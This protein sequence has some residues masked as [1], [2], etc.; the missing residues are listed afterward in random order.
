MKIS[1]PITLLDGVTSTGAGSAF[2]LGN[3]QAAFQASVVGTGA[4]T[5]TVNIE[6]S[7]EPRGSSQLWV[8]MGTI[9]LSGTTSA[10]DGFVCDA[11]WRFV[12]G[13]LT[14]VSGTGATVTVRMFE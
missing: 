10:T 3:A 6:V 4:Q 13:N 7:N 1:E 5:A 14:A 8:V 11:P 2:V 12:R 9:T